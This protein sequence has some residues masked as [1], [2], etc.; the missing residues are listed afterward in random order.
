MSY[1]PTPATINE[2]PEAS[3]PILET[4][5][6]QLGAVPNMFRL[7]SNSPAA[8]KGYV[9]LQAALGGGKLSPATR[10]RIALVVAEANGCDYC[11]AAHS[12]L[13]KTFAKFDDVELEAARRGTSGDPK[14]AAAVAFAK[15]LVLSRGAVAPSEIEAVRAAGYSDGEILEIVSHVA[16]NTLTNYVNTAFGTEIDFPQVDR[17]AA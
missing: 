17:I 3:R 12:Y 11:L 4:T 9:D 2:A 5:Q 6:K 13:G 15:A 16:L 7:V 10:E 8:L 1:L 14:A